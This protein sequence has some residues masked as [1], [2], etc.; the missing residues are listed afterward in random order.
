MHVRWKNN[1]IDFANLN[2]SEIVSSRVAETQRDSKM[3]V[4][5]EW[6]DGRDDDD[7]T[8]AWMKPTRLSGGGLRRRGVR[9]PI[10]RLDTK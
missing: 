7:D 5:G 8:H 10:Y 1:F 4:K 3:A 9:S 6:R 2:I